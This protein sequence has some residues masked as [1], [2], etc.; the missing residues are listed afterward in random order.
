MSYFEF[1]EQRRIHQPYTDPYTGLPIWKPPTYNSPY[2]N[3]KRGMYCVFGATLVV[4][5]TIT[6]MYFKKIAN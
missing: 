1:D 4:S 5:F 2:F 6:R 3:W